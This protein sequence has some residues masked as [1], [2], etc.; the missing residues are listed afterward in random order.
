MRLFS[1]GGTGDRLHVK[2][3]FAFCL[4]FGFAVV[5]QAMKYYNIQMGEKVGELFNKEKKN[6][7]KIPTTKNEENHTNKNTLWFDCVK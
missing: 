2:P 7:I 6:K 4:R 3:D 5:L 1:S